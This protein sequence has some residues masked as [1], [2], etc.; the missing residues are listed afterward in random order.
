MKLKKATKNHFRG[1]GF[2]NEKARA[3][4]SW[5]VIGLFGGT[6][7]CAPLQVTG[8]AIRFDAATVSGLPARNIG[9]ATMS[10]R[11]AA[12]DAVEEDGRITLFVGAAS[13]GGWQSVNGGTT[14]QPGVDREDVQALGA[15]A[16]GPWNKKIVW[17]GRC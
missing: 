7:L 5:G 9:S 14:V 13:G 16:I 10:G 15:V 2:V 6:M 11:I 12:V 1:K 17:V 3:H 8:Q 4:N